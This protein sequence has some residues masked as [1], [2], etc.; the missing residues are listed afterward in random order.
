M[1]IQ[2]K[3]IERNNPRNIMDNTNNEVATNLKSFQLLQ[4]PELKFRWLW[5]LFGIPLIIDLGIY[6][7]QEIQ[8]VQKMTCRMKML[9]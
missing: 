4:K 3:E 9:N 6:V 7:G 8:Y 2:E 5:L 1:E